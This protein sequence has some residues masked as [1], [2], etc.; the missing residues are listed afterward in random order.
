MLKIMRNVIKSKKK[1]KKGNSFNNVQKQIQLNP[2]IVAF[3]VKLKITF[4]YNWSAIFKKA[5]IKI[6]VKNKTVI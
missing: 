2:N 5:Y 6:F 4:S 3:C 1:K